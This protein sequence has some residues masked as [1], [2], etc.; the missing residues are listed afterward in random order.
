MGCDIHFRVQKRIAGEWAFAEAMIPDKWEEGRMRPETWYD[1]RNYQLF[2]I[3]ANV[4]NGY[5]F[6]GCDTG[7]PFIPIAEPRGLPDGL[8][9][10]K[11]YLGEHSFSWLTLVEL[12]AYDWSQ[13]TV[14]RG[15]VKAEVYDEVLR[16][17]EWDKY[18]EPSQANGG[19]SGPNIEHISSEEM[20]RKLAKI[21][22]EAKASAEGFGT[23]WPLH[24][25]KLARLE[26]TY[27]VLEWPVLY[28]EAAGK[29]Y[30]RTLPRL[31]RLASEVGG[32]ENVRVVFGFDS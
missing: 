29:F 6:A 10:E 13:E 1:G 9:P 11:H 12:L 19:I 32:P 23:Y 27:A 31:V 21:S 18:A 8:D 17:R 28:A 2:G 3:L 20:E 4:R 22:A 7:D 15:W 14:R 24:K 25:Q 30:T 5:G 16:H 26:N